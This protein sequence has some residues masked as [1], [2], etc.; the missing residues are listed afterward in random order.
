MSLE[1]RPDP[2]GAPDYIFNADVTDI[3]DGD[4]FDVRVDLGFEIRHIFRVRTRDIDTRETH[5]V[6]HSSEE[7]ERGMVHTEAFEDWV[8]ATK[9]E[10]NDDWPFYLYSQRY[11]RGAFGRVVGDVWSK[12][13][14]NWASRY[15]FNRFEDVSLYE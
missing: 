13:H 6:K 3:V 9:R 10:V 14:E 7:Y 1:D 2:S 8:Q 15:L 11:R 12:H 4:T 5:F